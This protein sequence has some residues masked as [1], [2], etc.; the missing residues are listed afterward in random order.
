MC[1][2]IYKGLESDRRIHIR[3]KERARAKDVDE[4]RLR[5]GELIVKKE[6]VLAFRVALCHAEGFV[7]V[8][9]QS[10]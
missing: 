3:G 9:S 1:G 10:E 5:R 8:S 7:S 6:D 2:Y 4:R